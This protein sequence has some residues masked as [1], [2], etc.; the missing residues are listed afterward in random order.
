M[1]TPDPL[2]TSPL[3][4]P[5]EQELR[6][7]ASE[8]KSEAGKYDLGIGVYVTRFGARGGNLPVGTNCTGDR[9]VKSEV[10]YSVFKQIR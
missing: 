2:A 4:L 7:E 8:P 6:T 3:D 10:Y 5:L 1:L 9:I